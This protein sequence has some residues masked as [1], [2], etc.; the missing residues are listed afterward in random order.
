MELTKKREL[1]S[2]NANCD[3]FLTTI[4]MRPKD[5]N[6]ISFI[7]IDYKHRSEISSIMQKAGI[8]NWND[9]LYQFQKNILI[10]NLS[11]GLITTLRAKIPTRTPIKQEHLHLA[12][13]WSPVVFLQNESRTQPQLI[14]QLQC[15]LHHKSYEKREHRE[16]GR[17]LWTS[18]VEYFQWWCCIVVRGTPHFE[19]LNIK[20]LKV[21]VTSNKKWIHSLAHGTH[22]TS[23]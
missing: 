15:I 16:R 14:S 22:S 5:R 13:A 20:R 9:L 17:C 10:P 4:L 3:L 11:I 8:N 6:K 2:S 23:F 19:I 1:T 18:F 12:A 21:A 7:F